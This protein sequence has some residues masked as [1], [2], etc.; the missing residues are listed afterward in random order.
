MTDHEIIN[1]AVRQVNE[2]KE[3][4]AKEEA[5]ARAE[6]TKRQKLATEVAR[7]TG[8]DYFDAA[9]YVSYAISGLASAKNRAEAIKKLPQTSNGDIY[10]RP[11]GY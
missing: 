3:R 1:E 11:H 6:Q 9:R 10:G 4:V 5:E 7:Q 8:I 2:W